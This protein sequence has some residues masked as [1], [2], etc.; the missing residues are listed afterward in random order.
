M[1]DNHYTIPEIARVA[2]E[3]NR[4]MQFVQNDACP[5]QPWDAENEFVQELSCN[6]V[7]MIRM[8][9]SAEEMHNEW[10]EEHK[11][12]GWTYGP[13]KDAERKTHPCLVPYKDLPPT[14]RHKTELMRAIVVTLSIV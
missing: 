1:K 10:C 3:A 13:V 6:G 7:R 5:S 12:A 14:Q 4:A 2:H 9:Y 8:G 11:A